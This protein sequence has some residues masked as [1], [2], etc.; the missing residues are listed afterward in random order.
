VAGAAEGGSTDPGEDGGGEAG[1]PEVMGERGE[2]AGLGETSPGFGGRKGFEEMTGGLL[3]RGE[4]G[5]S[6]VDSRDMVLMV[7]TG[8]AVVLD[9][10]RPLA[11]SPSPG[12][13]T[14][15]GGMAVGGGAGFWEVGGLGGGAVGGGPMVFFFE[16]PDGG[17]G[18]SLKPDI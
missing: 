3:A 12:M 17:G 14:A 7:E 16:S 1:D 11:M 10:P 5:P 13:I 6:L 4:L 18:G 9:D 15:G 2:I 8:F